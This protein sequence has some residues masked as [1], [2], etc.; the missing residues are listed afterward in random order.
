MLSDPG[1][2]WGR[3][4]LLERGPGTL[5]GTQR[6]YTA[7]RTP[8]FTYAEYS[9]GE[10]ELYDL[11]VDPDELESKHASSEYEGIRLELAKRLAALRDCAGESC[12]LGPALRLETVD[13][14][15]CVR[16]ASVLGTD[17]PLV[18]LV[19]FLA[20]GKSVARD[21]EPPF[22]LPVLPPGATKLRALAVLVDG[23]R[24]TLDKAIRV[25]S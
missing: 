21:A 20:D 22:E 25:C 13:E 6:L 10:R 15:D 16:A 5:A 4:I 11:A 17:E 14:G 1:L 24:L 2:E 23:R 19:D 3:D 18:E 12:R 9:T 8:R 7:I